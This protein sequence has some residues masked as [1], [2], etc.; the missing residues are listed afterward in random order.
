MTPI[1]TLPRLDPGDSLALVLDALRQQDPRAAADT[2]LARLDLGPGGLAPA[3]RV[4][5]AIA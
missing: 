4:Q 5:G 1:A 3:A 2:P